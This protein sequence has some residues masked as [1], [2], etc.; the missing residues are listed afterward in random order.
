MFSCLDAHI[1]TVTRGIHIRSQET[2]K[3]YRFVITL[4]LQLTHSQQG[5]GKAIVE[6]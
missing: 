5:L 1:I 2:L 6:F 3:P 4:F